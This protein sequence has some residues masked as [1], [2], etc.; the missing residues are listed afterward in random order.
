MKASLLEG[1]LLLGISL[2][3]VRNIYN[4][5]AIIKSRKNY[6]IIRY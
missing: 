5:N 6:H 2:Y 4:R 1:T 3:L